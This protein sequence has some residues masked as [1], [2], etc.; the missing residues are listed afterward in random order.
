MPRNIFAILLFFAATLCATAQNRISVKEELFDDMETTAMVN[1]EKDRNNRDCAL[2]IFH[3]VEPDGYY[4][5][6]GLIFI[7]ADNR[8]SRDSGEKTIFLHISEGAKLINILHRDDRIMSLRYEFVN[9]PLKARHTYHVYLGKV[10]PANANAKQYLRFTVSP[11]N[12]T[13]EVEEQPGMF[14]PWP[15]DPATGM[16]AK[17]L[18]LGDY[19]YRVQARQY[20]PT[21]G[22]AEMTDATK[23][24]DEQVSLRPAFGT[25]QMSHIDG[26]TVLIDG[27]SM[28]DYSNVRLDPGVHSIKISRPRYKLYQADFTVEEGKTVR[29]DPAF[30]SNFGSVRLQASAPGVTISLREVGSDRRLGTGSWQGELEAGDY[31]V[32][33]SAAGHRESVHNITV[34]AGGQNIAITL[35]APTPVYGSINVNSTPMGAS[36]KLDGKDVG[37]TPT[38]LSN[39][40]IGQHTVEVVV[41]EKEPFTQ[42]VEITEGDTREIFAD[43]AKQPDEKLH[44]VD[45]FYDLPDFIVHP[46]GY[47]GEWDFNDKDKTFKSLE[48]YLK[49]LDNSFYTDNVGWIS[50]RS[51]H[52]QKLGKYDGIFSSLV[53]GM[54]IK[55]IYTIN[56]GKEYEVLDY[57]RDLNPN[58]YSNITNSYSNYNYAYEIKDI[59]GKIKLELYN[60]PF[61]DKPTI[62]ISYNF[63]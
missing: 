33:S 44:K 41:P 55:I 28:A 59:A 5:D 15:V 19:T 30:E 13:L 21:G 24:H 36:V 26:A 35:P 57:F 48:K 49:K 47:N 3:N 2:V 6:A 45:N 20:H 23:P 39:V 50:D 37:A 56:D 32:V 16:A 12:A 51:K 63:N 61:H 22:K 40:L 10:V 62:S 14:V 54:C 29:L 27:E 18:P 1:P 25:L 17:A 7:K 58:G 34:P 4:F 42:I 9:G 8:V 60:L 38:I 46:L 11:A 53:P 52:Y 31:T 43:I